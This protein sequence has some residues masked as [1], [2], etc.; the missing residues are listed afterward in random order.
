VAVLMRRWSVKLTAGAFPVSIFILYMISF[1]G[2]A[3]YGSYL[4]LYLAS[5]GFSQSQIGLTVS[6]STCF[7]MLFQMLWGAISDRAKAKNTVIRGLYLLSAVIIL[8]YYL[9]VNFWIVLIVL[10][11]YAS[12]Y[13]GVSPL[14]DNVVLELSEGQTWNFGQ[15]RTGG[16]IGYCLTV[17]LVGFVIGD[18]YGR[19]FAIT[20][21]LLLCCFFLMRR[22]PRVAGRRSGQE[23][24]SFRL[25]LKNKPLMVVMAYYLAFSL[26]LSLFY[27]FYPIH[28]ISIG[29]TS[30]QVGIMLF[31]CAVTEIPCLILAGR[32]VKRIG[33]DRVLIISGLTTVI[34]WVLLFFVQN[35]IAA[36]FANLLHGIG[37]IGFS[38]CVVVYVNE[39]VP[40]DLRASGQS[41]NVLIG[42]VFSRVIFGY[43]GGLASQAFGVNWVMLMAGVVLA[44]ATL[45]FAI[46][47]SH[48]REGFA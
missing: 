25:L 10:A 28:F 6:V 17:L 15:I 35:P 48:H 42:N 24:S 26:G 38:Y 23:R 14:L 8:L 4:N 5:K 40:G 9:S 16:T 33:L 22:V 46:W 31:F 3:V 21:A 27:S 7:V 36:I 11:L 29:G 39:H 1:S 45:L 44:G 19:I 18:N 30:A 41:F 47:S 2:Q 34:R 20:S 32:V 13:T 12:V 43:L 37:Y